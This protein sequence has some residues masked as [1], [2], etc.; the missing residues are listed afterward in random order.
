MI[1]ISIP[2]QGTR[3]QTVFLNINT[4]H[5]FMIGTVKT[6]HSS[7]AETLLPN[8][9]SAGTNSHLFLIAVKIS[10]NLFNQSRELPYSWFLKCFFYNFNLC[11]A[12]F[13][14]AVQILNS[15][16]HFMVIIV[17]QW[18]GMHPVDIIN[19]RYIFEWH[20]AL[21]SIQFG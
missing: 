2:Y 7:S 17:K 9:L 13:C 12:I 10:Q 18:S 14:L 3:Q 21:R 6:W 11:N 15:L 4:Y 8:V 20:R 19:L 1:I 16:H 5:L